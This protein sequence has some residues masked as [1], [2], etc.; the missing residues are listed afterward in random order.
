VEAERAFLSASGGGCRAPIGAL[1][2]VVGDELDLLGGY[3]SPDGARATIAR[4]RGPVASGEDLGRGLAVELH[5]GAHVRA[6]A[7][8]AGPE[9]R[10][11]SPPRVMVT[12]AH[13]QAGK[14]VSA[15]RDAGLDPIPVPAIA[16]RLDPPR[17][18]LDAAAGLLH[19]TDDLVAFGDLVRAL[20]STES[21]R[22]TVSDTPILLGIHRPIDEIL[23][24][25]GAA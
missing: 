12:R 13:D 10:R 22:S 2:I 1:A 19:E 6:T 11:S 3:A 4:R 14:L 16:I 25:L 24:L 8:T 17:G 9:G 15:L 21:R 23:T 7:G 20:R 5:S 18:D